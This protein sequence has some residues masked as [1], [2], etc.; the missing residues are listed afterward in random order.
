TSPAPSRN[1]SLH[2][3]THPPPTAVST[4]PKPP[5]LSLQTSSGRPRRSYQCAAAAFLK[6]APADANPDPCAPSALLRH[7]R[8]RR[9]NPRPTLRHSG[10]NKGRTPDGATPESN[11]EM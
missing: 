9:E 4:A 11:P 8:S 10:N 5:N 1:P 6:T 2:A 7:R 3:P